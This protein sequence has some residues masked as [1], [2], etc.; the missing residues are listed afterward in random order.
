MVVLD[1]R[2]GFL[3][4]HP[5][6]VINERDGAGDLLVAKF[7]AVLYQLCADHVGDGQGTVLITFLLGHFIQLFEQRRR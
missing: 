6:M 3:H 7:L 1:I 2:K 4:M 5:V